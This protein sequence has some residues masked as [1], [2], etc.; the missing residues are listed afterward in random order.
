MIQ[1]AAYHVVDTSGWLEYL[2][3]TANASQFATAIQ[4]GDHLVVPTI[5]LVEVFRWVLRERG[6]ADA[7]QAMAALRQGRIV[8]LDQVIALEAGRCGIAYK[9]PLA[10]SIIYATAQ[11]HGAVLLTQDAH[12]DGLPHVRDHPKHPPGNT[13]S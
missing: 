8:D 12:F 5:V 11:L 1:P 7:L 6:E 4:D 10:D 2:A 3:D 9:L 13:G